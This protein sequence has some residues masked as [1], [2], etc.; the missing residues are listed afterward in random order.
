MQTP[1]GGAGR[2]P[3]ASL[4]LRPWQPEL[5]QPELRPEFPPVGLHGG[6]RGECPFCC[7]ICP[8]AFPARWVR[9]EL[10][11][12]RAE[13]AHLVT[14]VEHHLQK[15]DDAKRRRGSSKMR[16]RDTKLQP[17]EPTSAAE[18][19]AMITARERAA[20]CQN[21]LDIV[22]IRGNILT[23]WRSTIEQHQRYKAKR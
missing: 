13:L 17:G 7:K 5:R 10:R 4:S 8:E 23:N 21:T 22:N 3:A 19:A 12:E 1:R 16:E 11:D 15:H 18:V 9:D 14:L 2:R 20:G 6:R